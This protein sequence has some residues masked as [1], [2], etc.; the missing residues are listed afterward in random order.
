MPWY[1]YVALNSENERVEGHL[2]ADMLSVAKDLL[3]EKGLKSP[4]ISTC[5]APPSQEPNDQNQIERA[6]TQAS[7]KVDPSKR[8]AAII[9]Q[10]KLFDLRFFDP[11]F[12]R[13]LQF[14]RYRQVWTTDERIVFFRKLHCLISSGTTIA[15]SLEIIAQD[16]SNPSLSERITRLNLGITNQTVETKATDQDLPTGIVARCFQS[17]GLFSDQQ[18]AMIDAAEMSAGFETI[19]SPISNAEQE[20]LDFQRR[21]NSMLMQPKIVLAIIWLGSPILSY[22]FATVSINFA[23]LVPHSKA[24]IEIC[25][26]LVSPIALIFEWLTPPLIIW[27]VL[28]LLRT[29]SAKQKLSAYLM[30]LPVIGPPL[31]QIQVAIF[32]KT[33]GQTLNSG[34]QLQPALSVSGRVALPSVA[35]SV[36]KTTQEGQPISDGFIHEQIPYLAY[37]MVRTGEETGKLNEMLIHAARIFEEE[38]SHQLENLTQ[39]IEPIF[40]ALVGLIVGGV[41]L[42]SL[43]P[44][45]ELI[46]S[47]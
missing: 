15:R 42:V 45:L 30:R 27:L 2:Q 19:F 46:Q 29:E 16:Q 41:C 23:E 6:L 28:R 31:K 1:K 3:R 44:M 20:R 7:K 36:L 8:Y 33:L 13:V 9:S 21:I 47:L 34:L 32:L 14:F 10:K 24:W 26:I 11:I 43:S 17:S 35:E 4:E 25:K 40:M 12:H 5:Q 38:S 18:I 22:A 39:L 37:Q